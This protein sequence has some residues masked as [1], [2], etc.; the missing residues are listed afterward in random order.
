M[1]KLI[2]CPE[3]CVISKYNIASSAYGTSHRVS[4]LVELL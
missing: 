2:Y 1:S 4:V 3:E